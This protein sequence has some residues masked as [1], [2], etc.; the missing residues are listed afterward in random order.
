MVDWTNEA[1]N[2]ADVIGSGLIFMS[3]SSHFFYGIIMIHELNFGVGFEV[4]INS[5]KIS[6]MLILHLVLS[7]RRKPTEHSRGSYSLGSI[8]ELSSGHV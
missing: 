6:G 2:G 1:A 7:Q 8:N 3:A 4:V 5:T